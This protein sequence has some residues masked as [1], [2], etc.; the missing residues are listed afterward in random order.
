M[1][2]LEGCSDAVGY[3]HVHDNDGSLDSHDVPGQGTLPWEALAPHV[4]HLAADATAMLE[5]FEPESSILRHTEAGLGER[6]RQ[7]LA[8]GQQQGDSKA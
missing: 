1:V 8:L 2:S 5:L 7:W 3:L 4:V 6:L